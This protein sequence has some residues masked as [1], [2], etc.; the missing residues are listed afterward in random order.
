MN[1]GKRSLKKSDFRT[2]LRKGNAK[3]RIQSKWRGEKIKQ[4]PLERFELSTPGL[5]DQCSNP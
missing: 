4:E 2:S 1:K 3:V 5:L